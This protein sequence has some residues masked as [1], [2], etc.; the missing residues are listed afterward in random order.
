MNSQQDPELF[1]LAF[2]SKLTTLH[3][4]QDYKYTGI[5]FSEKYLLTSNSLRYSGAKDSF[6]LGVIS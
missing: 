1:L 3:K 4:V 2:S 5:Y 6:L